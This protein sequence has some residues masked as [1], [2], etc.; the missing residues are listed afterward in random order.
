MAKDH[1]AGYALLPDSA[2]LARSYWGLIQRFGE[3]YGSQSPTSSSAIGTDGDVE[4]NVSAQEKIS[5]KGLLLLRA[6]MK[7]VFN[8]AQTFKYQQP[9]D[10]EDNKLS[11]EL[12]RGQLFSESFVCEVME[13]LVTRFF[14]FTPRDLRRWEDEP[15]EWEYVIFLQSRTGP[16]VVQDT[17]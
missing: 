9:E 13:V 5:L 12:I 6:C 2:S 11:Q 10:K 17:S 8:P 14:V 7:M 1:P 3:T 4:D 15:D 16:F